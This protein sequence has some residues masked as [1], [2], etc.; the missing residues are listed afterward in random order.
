[1]IVIAKSCSLHHL[2]PKSRAADAVGVLGAMFD[3]KAASRERLRLC[4]CGLAARPC[5]LLGPT[6]AAGSVWCLS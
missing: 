2:P 6:R 5:R 3:T 1:M 4:G